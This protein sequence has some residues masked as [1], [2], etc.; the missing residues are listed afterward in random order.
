MF[1]PSFHRAA[2]GW[3]QSPNAQTYGLHEAAPLLANQLR[4][5]PKKYISLSI[6]GAAKCE[7]IYTC[8]YTYIYVYIHV[9]L[10][11]HVIYVYLCILKLNTIWVYIYIYIHV[12]G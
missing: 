7:Y 4:E 11:T 6:L 9:C 1:S 12:Y 8:I 5:V 10:Y 3:L 2:S